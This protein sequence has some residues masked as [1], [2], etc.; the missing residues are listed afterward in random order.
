MSTRENTG[1]R[2]INEYVVFV[3]TLKP[4]FAYISKCIFLNKKVFY[5]DSKFVTKGQI[6]NKS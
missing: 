4:L 2:E 5:F 6:D 3:N 1:S